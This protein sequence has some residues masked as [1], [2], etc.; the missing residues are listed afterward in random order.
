M[1]IGLHLSF[2]NSVIGVVK[3]VFLYHASKMQGRLKSELKSKK[4]FYFMITAPIPG[5]PFHS[6]FT[7]APIP[8][9]SKKV[10]APSE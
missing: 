1:W 9:S 8:F 4:Y 6:P 7:H 10:E 3:Y 2:Y 5:S